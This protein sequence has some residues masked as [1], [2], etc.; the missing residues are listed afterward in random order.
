[1]SSSSVMST[2]VTALSPSSSGESGRLL[3]DEVA[4]LV[5]FAD[6]VVEER[7]RHPAAYLPR[8]VPER[9]NPPPAGSSAG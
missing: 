2:G 7:H 5:A 4:G 1:M 3:E 9:S 8:A 6:L